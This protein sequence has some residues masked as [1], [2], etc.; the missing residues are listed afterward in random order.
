MT[1]WVIVNGVLQFTGTLEVN[2]DFDID[3]SLTA[4]DGTFSDLKLVEIS[5]PAVPTITPVGTTGATTY[6][7]KI[8][9]KDGITT[10]AASTEGTTAT[11]NATLSSTNYNAITWAAV[12]NTLDYDIYRTTGGAT[13]G[14]IGTTTGIVFNDTGL[15]GDAST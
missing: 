11:G 15:A 12:S 14:L 2:G 4:A 9:G 8:V 6:G 10:T 3:G 13:Q 5:T 7:Y 1:N